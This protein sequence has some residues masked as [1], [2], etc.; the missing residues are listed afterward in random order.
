MQTLL[1][2]STIL[3][4]SLTNLNA[5]KKLSTDITVNDLKTQLYYLASD[6]L[7]GRFPGSKG[8]RLAA[9]YIARS[10]KNAGL[11]LYKKTGLQ[12]FEV[13][14]RQELGKKNSFAFDGK[15]LKLTT[16]FAPFPFS[17]NGK[18]EGEVVFAGFGFDIK[19]DTFQWSDYSNV[20]VKGKI[21]MML[22]GA[23]EST[24]YQSLFDSYSDDIVKAINARDKGAIAVILISG[25]KF[26]PTEK[27]PQMNLRESS[28]GIPAFQVKRS[29]ANKILSST[30]RS[31]DDLENRIQSDFTP[32]SL[33]LKKKLN[34]SS[35]IV[36]IKATTHN[37]IGFVYASDT[38]KIKS[39]VVVGAH[40]DHL[41]MG[42]M[43][44]SSRIQDTI[45][46]HNG[47][48]DNGSGVTVLLELA[49]KFQQERD[50]LKHNIIFVAFGAEEMGILGSK[51]FTE[52]A[53]VDIRSIKAMINLDMVG[54]LKEDTMLQV[55]GTGTSKEAVSIIN[56]VNQKYNFNLRMAP[57]GYGPSDHAAFYGKNIPVFFITTGAHTDY[58]TP[59]DDHEK[60]NFEGMQKVAYFTSDI[61]SEL[62]LTEPMLTFQEAGPQQGTGTSRRFRVTFGI[63]PDVNGTV[64]NG[65][66]VE[67]VT[68][69]KPAY[70][71]G[72][73]KGDIITS[74]DGK[75]VKNIQDY[76]V[77]LSQLKA[78][79]SVN[80]EVIRN[81]KKELLII[82]L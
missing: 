33:S 41:G 64:E 71:G 67:F 24:K 25:N 49:A 15:K 61:L 19:N 60:I 82:Q 7:G 12:N 66:L 45:A 58:H 80:V 1:L 14:T 3:V 51:Y 39:Y 65:L 50:K 34:L 78:G 4:L 38:S 70:N 42:G 68:K 46:V 35:E 29:A 79:Q 56:H 40:Y 32:G 52:H 23:P 28:A 30:G 10:Y 47:A 18:A 74:V 75:T 73:Q 77:R 13:L 22:R 81:N 11:T 62:A 5:Q 72:M 20:D 6:S 8:D 2:I 44:S 27:L 63:M 48:D 69:G 43:G 55:N 59:M 9:D 31:V 26:D 16:D 37:I 76:M 17:A 21:V 53:P 36:K 57:E 54:R